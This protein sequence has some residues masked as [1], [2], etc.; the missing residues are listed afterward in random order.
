MKFRLYSFSL[1][2]VLY[3]TKY[4]ISYHLSKKEINILSKDIPMFAQK[5]ENRLR[6]N[7]NFN[8][9]KNTSN[10]SNNQ[11]YEKTLDNSAQLIVTPCSASSASNIRRGQNSSSTVSSL[12]LGST[13][14]CPC[15]SSS[16]EE[17]IVCKASPPKAPKSRDCPVP[18]GLD[19]YELSNVKQI[20]SDGTEACISDNKSTNVVGKLGP[21][22]YAITRPPYK[23]TTCD[24]VVIIPGETF[25]NPKDFIKREKAWFTLSA[26]IINSF[27]Y[28]K[29]DQKD[30]QNIKNSLMVERITNMPNDIYGA[31]GCIEFFDSKNMNRIVMCFD[32]TTKNNIKDTYTELLKC[33]V[34][35]GL[36]SISISKF[37][38]LIKTSCMGKDIT[39][40]KFQNLSN[41]L[42]KY[43]E[44]KS[45][46][47][48]NKEDEEK[49]KKKLNINPAYNLVVPGNLE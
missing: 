48:D 3:F 49:L 34:N 47:F 16:D 9:N 29:P 27:D 44:N 17:K 15:S 13:S 5:S 4:I 33:R 32:E 28:K 43:S 25:S 7:T 35:G 31:P 12:S 26:Y 19:P 46:I 2:I 20:D 40:S 36:S 8:S 21:L 11:I 39:I 38:D 37:K 10:Y 24:Q 30:S 45:S 18:Q 1:F 42:K 14:V 6:K 41:L 23:I 22:S